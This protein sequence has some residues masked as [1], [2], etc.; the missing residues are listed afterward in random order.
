MA[1]TNEHVSQIV[2]LNHYRDDY[3]LTVATA[4]RKRSHC[5]SII[6][7]LYDIMGVARILLWG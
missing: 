6:I 2:V 1:E 7:S 3:Q 4:C 5:V